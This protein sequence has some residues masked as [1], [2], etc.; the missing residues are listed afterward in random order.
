[1]SFLEHT[2]K[3]CSIGKIENKIKSNCSVLLGNFLEFY[4]FTLFAVLLPIIAPLLFP[5]EN[6]LTSFTFGYIFLAIGFFARPAGVVIF[7]YIGDRY[8]R[9][10][11]LIIAILMM[12]CATFGMGLLPAYGVIGSYSLVVLVSCRFL[13]GLS[14]GGKYSGTGL[15]LTEDTNAADNSVQSEFLTT[16]GLLGAFVA[17]I[18]AAIVAFDIFPQSSWRFLFFIGGGL[19]FFILWLRFY[20]KKGSLKIKSANYKPDEFCLGV[21]FKEH[22]VS[23]I[24]TLGIGALM[25]VPFSLMT[26]FI[27]TYFIALGIYTKT[28]LMFINALVI[29][30]CAIITMYF[31]ILSRSRYFNSAKIMIYASLSM[32]IFAVPFFL[33]VGSGSLVCFIVA[34][35]VLILLSQLFVVPG[36]AVMIQ[37]FPS[38]IRYMGVAIGNCLGLAILGGPTPYIS[39]YLIKHTRLSWSPAVYLLSVALLGFICTLIAERKLNRQSHGVILNNKQFCS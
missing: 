3:A 14:A 38:D 35:L 9:K 32:A 25:N 23:L 34:E 26:G 37:M 28:T 31:G 20:R 5:S 19:G 2:Y 30:F 15:L 29:L 27:N 21:L 33:L 7:G 6:I 22:K 39:G 4:N 10:I 16:F 24:C 13:Q 17:S 8:N 11:S 1:V 12:S 36:A 18:A